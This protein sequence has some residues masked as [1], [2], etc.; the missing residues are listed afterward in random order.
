MNKISNA[1]IH[2]L[3]YAVV[4]ENISDNHHYVI[5]CKFDFTVYTTAYVVVM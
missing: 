2:C 1:V 4:N 3:S 5:H